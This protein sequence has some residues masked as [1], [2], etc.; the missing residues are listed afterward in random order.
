MGGLAIV[1]G[2][3]AAVLLAV[4]MVSF[5]HVF[6]ATNL[7]VLLAV[8]STVLLTGLAGWVDDLLGMQQWGKAF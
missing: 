4:A 2:F 8:L 3:G 5:F 7:V 1:M 6:P